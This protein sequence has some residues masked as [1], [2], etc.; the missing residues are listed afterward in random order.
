MHARELWSTFRW[1]SSHSER[2]NPRMLDSGEYI[3]YGSIYIY[4]DQQSMFTLLPTNIYVVREW[5]SPKRRGNDVATSRWTRQRGQATG[6]SGCLGYSSILRG[7]ADF[8]HIN[9]RIKIYIDSDPM[10]SCGILCD[11]CVLVC[12]MVVVCQ[13][14]VRVYVCIQGHPR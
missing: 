14:G 3:F 5:A 12:C 6:C 8:S 9:N 4:I 13:M 7:A 10:L 1:G 2:R 11:F